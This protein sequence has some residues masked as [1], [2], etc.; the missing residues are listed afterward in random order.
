MVKFMCQ[1]AVAEARAQET[2]DYQLWQSGAFVKGLKPLFG[3]DRKQEAVVVRPFPACGK[4]PPI[5]PPRHQ[6]PHV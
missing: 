4:G 5:D 2:H 1:E 3:A 6:W